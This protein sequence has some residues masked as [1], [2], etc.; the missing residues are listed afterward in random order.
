MKKQLTF[1]DKTVAVDCSAR[2]EAAALQLSSAIVIE[3]QIYFS[4]MLGK[5]LAYY[6][7]ASMPGVYQLESEAFK[8]ILEESQQLVGNIYVRFNTVSTK[9]CLVSDYVG[10][11]PVTDFKI[12]KKEAFVP[13]WL[14]LDHDG[15]VFTGAYGW[16]DSDPGFSNT[17]QV[18]GVPVKNKSTLPAD[19]RVSPT[20]G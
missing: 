8:E 10:P 1:Y 20:A 14:T 18:R 7:D 11:P 15:Q 12:A 19:A 3:I 2:A 13:T 16:K 4:C 17:R 6:S 9:I 5:R